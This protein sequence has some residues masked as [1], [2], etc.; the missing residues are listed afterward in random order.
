MSTVV[1]TLV[2]PYGSS[3]VAA[4]GSL[5]AEWDD[6][7]NLDA[8]GN[9]KSQWLPGDYRDLLIHHDDTVEVVAV[10][11]T[12]GT[13]GNPSAETLSRS[14]LLGFPFVG[15]AQALQYLP[16]GALAYA[17]KGN[18]GREA[19]NVGREVSVK[20]VT[21][22]CLALITYPVKFTRYRLQTPSMELDADETFPI[23]VYVYYQEI[24]DESND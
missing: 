11:A 1:A 21:V 4:N 13:F 15:E 17:W 2:V 10:R 12:A 7:T 14:E 18:V 16:A 5:I 23:R 19:S 8:D 3:A 22:P 24:S 9:V 20:S 6:S